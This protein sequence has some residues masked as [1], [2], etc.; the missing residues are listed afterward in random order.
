MLDFCNS[1]KQSYGYMSYRKIKWPPMSR[2]VSRLCQ[3]R[4]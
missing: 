3:T 1:E 2:R 4:R